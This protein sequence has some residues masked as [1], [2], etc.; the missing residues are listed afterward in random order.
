MEKVCFKCKRLL[1]LEQFYK[2]PRMKDGHLNKCIDCNIKD[3]AEHRD[4]NLE[5]I[6]EYD[7][8]RGRTEKRKQ[9]CRD[10]Q[11]AHPEK[12]YEYLKKYRATHPGR[13]AAHSAAE[14]GKKK[15]F[16][17]VEKCVVCGSK[18]Q[19]QMHHHDYS[20]KTSVIVLCQKCHAAVHRKYDPLKLDIE[21]LLEVNNE[22]A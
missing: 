17:A 11:K 7:R 2:H 8:M 9:R 12:K 5:R 15:G 3:V 14:L 6:R 10:Y 20:Q 16:I 4:K 13:N 21:K 18:D 22:R 19:L 1:P